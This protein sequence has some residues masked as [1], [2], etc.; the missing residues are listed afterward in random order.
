MNE[1]GEEWCRGLNNLKRIVVSPFNNKFK[2]KDDKYLVGKSDENA[3][4]Y[5]NL[6]FVRRDI[7]E[8][9]LPPNIKVIKSC[10]FFWCQ[11]LRRIEFPTNSN[12]HTIEKYAFSSSAIEEISIPSE[13]LKICEHAFSFCKNLRRIEFP[14][15]SHLQTIET[16]AF[17]EIAIEEISIPSTVIKIGEGAFAFC[18]NLRKV[19]IPENSNL[20]TIE[21]Y[22]FLGTAIEEIYF[23]ANFSELSNYWNHL[24]S[25]LKIIVVS[26]FNKKYKFIEGKYLVS[27][28]DDNSEEYDNLLFVR[29]DIKEFSFPPNIKV[30][31]PL[32]FSE[33][34]NLRR[35]EFPTNS[36][37]HTIGENAFSYLGIEEISIPP[38]VSKI[39][40]CA[41][42]YCENLKVIEIPEKSK[43]VS[44]RS[45]LSINPNVIIMKPS[46][47]KKND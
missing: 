18:N 5:D 41:F 7:N 25:N 21:E 34:S 11:N 24:I 29:C 4:E 31:K 35:I 22:A 2:F 28:S 9:F 45:L 3:E 33:C 27:K 44:F 47:F 26:P 12:L 39:G 30:I 37:L 43:L 42:N 15:N 16:V 8:F 14:I 36:N 20:Q 1:L 19:E 40:G 10:A 23:P 46:S 38:S 32:A 13:V 17:I 6:L